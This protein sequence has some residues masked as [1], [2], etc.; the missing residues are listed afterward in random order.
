MRH[1]DYYRHTDYSY[2]KDYSGWRSRE[3]HPRVSF[4]IFLIIL[5][6]AL[7]IATNDLLGLGSVSSYF[8]WQ[9]AMVFIGVL[10]LFNLHFTGGIFMIALGI[11]FFKD[12]ILIISPETFN[13]FYWP[14]VIGFVGLSF[15][16]SSIFRRKTKFDK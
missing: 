16:L 3:H 13:T 15:I 7:L 10:M 14:A 11:W 4:G 8:T 6:L 5:G 2:H 9:T 12:H 1:R